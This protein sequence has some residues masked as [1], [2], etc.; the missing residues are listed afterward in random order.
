[1]TRDFLV[2][3]A[4]ISFALCSMDL[5]SVRYYYVTLWEPHSPFTSSHGTVQLPPPI[6][7][8]RR[9]IPG[10]GYHINNQR[11]RHK[12]IRAWSSS[13]F[14]QSDRCRSRFLIFLVKGPFSKTTVLLRSS[15]SQCKLQMDTL[16]SKPRF[17]A[18]QYRTPASYSLSPGFKPQPD[19]QLFW[20]RF[21]SGCSVPHAN[22]G[23]V[24]SIRLW[25]LPFIIFS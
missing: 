10:L 11:G 3:W 16:S 4:N 22:V 15:P 23:I 18:Y 9:E 1:M 19:I 8:K 21:L 17:T 2:S 13:C 20:Q 7:I 12:Q 24:P 25:L 6:C 14:W 5:I